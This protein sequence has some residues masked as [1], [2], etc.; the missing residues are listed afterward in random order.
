LCDP[1]SP[2]K[3]TTQFE[4]QILTF[5]PTVPILNGQQMVL[6][7]QSYNEPVTLSKLIS[8]LDKTTGEVI[9][10]NPRC[11][12]DS[13]A[14]VVELRTTRPIPLELFSEFKQLGRVTLRDGGK[15]VAAGIV[16]SI[17]SSLSNS[18]TSTSSSSS[19]SSSSGSSNTTS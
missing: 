7:L 13:V 3:L 1:E 17:N 19:S 5:N 16:T 18:T 10:K 8:Q 14:A 6:H 11:L 15:T 9:R 4:A 2:I 12:V